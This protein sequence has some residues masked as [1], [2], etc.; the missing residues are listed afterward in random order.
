MSAVPAARGDCF[1]GGGEAQWGAVAP[2]SSFLLAPPRAPDPLR[3]QIQA[4][5]LV[6]CLFQGR[7]HAPMKR[8]SPFSD[9]A[10]LRGGKGK[11]HATP[12][13]TDV[14]TVPLGTS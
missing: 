14:S 8:L 12:V 3:I 10:R 4:C 7:T 9:W 2:F 1:S 13:Q 5:M 6:V 11:L